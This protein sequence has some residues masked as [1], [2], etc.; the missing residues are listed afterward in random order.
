M[1]VQQFKSRQD[2]CVL[3]CALYLRSM[4][5]F[6]F[7]F[8]AFQNS[9]VQSHTALRIEKSHTHHSDNLP[10]NAGLRQPSLAGSRLAMN[11]A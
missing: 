8:K 1:N 11:A 10:D 3:I 2:L 6:E 9:S 4:W 5:Y 7:E